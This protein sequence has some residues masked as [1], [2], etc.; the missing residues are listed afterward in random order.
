MRNTSDLKLRDY[1]RVFWVMFRIGLFTF[2]GG[3]AMLPQ[4]SAEFVERRKWMKQEEMVDIFAVAQSLP[5][6]VAVNAS[7]LVG[8]RLGGQKCALVSALGSTLP[9]FLVLIFV[10]LGYQAFITNQYVAGA[11]VGIRAAVTGIL[12]AT[13]IKLGKAALKN[14]FS[15]VLFGTAMAL[16]FISVN[17]IW[18]ILGGLAVGLGHYAVM[19]R[20]AEK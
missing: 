19:K 12:A 6:V 13:V 15:W 7:M 4:M 9:S 17:P 18:I 20:S 16:T 10:S 5:G 14:V 11:M 8:Y 3:L 2:G 1:V